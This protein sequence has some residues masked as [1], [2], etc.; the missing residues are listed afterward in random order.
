MHSFLNI[1]TVFNDAEDRTLDKLSLFYN[2]IYKLEKTIEKVIGSNLTNEQIKGKRV[3]IKPN[4]VRHSKNIT[5]EVCLRTND[6]FV[7]AALKVMFE[8]G[9]AKVIIGDAPIQGCNWDRIISGSLTNE[10]N[11]LSADYNIPVLVKD[12]RRRIYNVSDNK[13]EAGIRPL[14]DYLIFD[15]GRESLLD[16]VT[17]TGQTRFRV[18]NYD[19][20]LMSTAHSPGV[21]KYCISR[22]LFDADIIISLPKI[23]THQKTGITG[24]L[25]N[26]VGINGDKDFLPHHRIGGT[27]W[28]GDCYPGG[29]YLRYWSELLLDNANRRQGRN[30]F[31]FWQKLSS[32]F[33]ILSCPG[34]EHNI[35][36]GWHG[37]DTTWR[38][39]MDLN[40]IA[41]Y[42]TADGTL[43]K[44]PQRQIY[45]LCD[46]IIAGQGDGPLEPEPHPLGI[47]SFTND[48]AI[49][50]RAMALLMGL[51]IDKIP[52][53]ND[54]IINEKIDC[55][56]TLDG[57]RIMLEDLKHYSI[58]TKPPI[59]WAN[60]FNKL[61]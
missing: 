52:L 29:S 39:V 13:P 2:D 12:F 46:G 21:H 35:A 34:P 60:Y 15:L 24:A 43:S 4:W 22:E 10:I 11:N 14:T 59:G 26:I 30:S 8:M 38:M 17:G 37:N 1:K 9:P 58:Y 41:G 20:D 55:E 6:K 27:G 47:I 36:A 49:N 7:L 31:W 40:K 25:K 3:L 61:Q 48:S 53:L 33:W 50:D 5:D 16:I 44:T 51:P 57:K 18:T 19:P 23:K 28:G 45:S 32:L 56:M 54:N 42:G